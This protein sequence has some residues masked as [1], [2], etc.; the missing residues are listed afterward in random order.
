MP[1]LHASMCTIWCRHPYHSDIQSELFS[2][3][4]MSNSGALRK[5]WHLFDWV[6]AM[7]A[8]AEADG[9]AAPVAA[10][11]ILKAWN[12]KVPRTY[13]VAGNKAV[14]LK[15][16]L[17]LMPTAALSKMAATISEFGWEN[18][19]WSEDS[20]ASKRLYAPSVFKNKACPT[21]RRGTVTSESTVLWARTTA[22]LCQTTWGKKGKM[23]KTSLEGLAEMAAWVHR[24]GPLGCVHEVSIQQVYACEGEG[25]SGFISLLLIPEHTVIKIACGHEYILLIPEHTVIKI[26]CGHE[27]MIKARNLAE[28]VYLSF[29]V[30]LMVL[31]ERFLSRFE[32]NEAD[33]L[34]LQLKV[35]WVWGLCLGTLTQ[36]CP[37]MS[38]K[39]CN[40]SML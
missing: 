33:G 3:A 21:S 29:G 15:N 14:A 2:T 25:Y 19:V 10:G 35:L 40:L 9:S 5:P 28:E 24:L 27:Y 37:Q 36:S 18:V 8:L 7:Q 16:L 6:S 23:D 30:S 11:P 22:H 32:Q 1:E 31:R 34:E 26:A 13:Q 17:E 12:T 39:C 38:A 20:L 4:M